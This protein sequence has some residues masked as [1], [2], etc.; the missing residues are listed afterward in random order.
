MK[1]LNLIEMKIDG[2]EVFLPNRK[3]YYHLTVNKPDVL[4]SIKQNGLSLDFKDTRKKPN[5]NIPT[6]RKAIYITTNPY[7]L[8]HPDNGAGSFFDQRT[9]TVVNLDKKKNTSIEK[10]N[11][12]VLLA[13][14]RDDIKELKNKYSDFK[15]EK[16]T[17]YPLLGTEGAYAYHIN[18]SIPPEMIKTLGEVEVLIGEEGYHVNY[19]LDRMMGK[20]EN[21]IRDLRHEYPYLFRDK[22][23]IAL[24]TQYKEPKQFGICKSKDS[25]E[26]KNEHLR[27]FYI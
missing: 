19:S 16:D 23:R 21:E 22:Y 13:I 1:V 4:D 25:K 14:K 5:A 24:F 10:K 8:I 26:H 17:Q 27:P 18:K 2:R 3:Y 15:K 11:G 6:E 9:I 20:S 12:L 7:K